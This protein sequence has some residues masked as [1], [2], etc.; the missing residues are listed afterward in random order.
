MFDHHTSHNNEWCCRVLGTL[1]HARDSAGPFFIH[2]IW[3]QGKPPKSGPYDLNFAEEPTQA[4]GHWDFPKVTYAFCDHLRFQ[5]GA[6]LLRSQH[7]CQRTSPAR[8][9]MWTAGNRRQFSDLRGYRV[10][11]NRWW[12]CHL[13]SYAPSKPQ[14]TW[15]RSSLPL[16]PAWHLLISPFNKETVASSTELWAG[17]YVQL[18]FNS[19]VVFVLVL[20]LYG[21]FLFIPSDI[22]FPLVAVMKSF[23]SGYLNWDVSKWA[24]WKKNGK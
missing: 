9:W 22:N 21:N 5:S 4:Q 24:N 15:S 23:L 10:T 17:N 14:V 3:A 2:Y 18:E 6:H 13:L 16:T 20:I 19:G 1:P 7:P 8:G 11:S 12:L